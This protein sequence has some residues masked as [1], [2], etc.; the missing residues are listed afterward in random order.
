MIAYIAKQIMKFRRHLAEL[1][2]NNYQWIAHNRV[3]RRELRFKG[4]ITRYSR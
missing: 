4:M 2:M 1:H 3:Q